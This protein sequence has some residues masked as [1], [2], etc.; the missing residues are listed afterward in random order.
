M[1]K[2]T[3]IILMSIIFLGL[4]LVGYL[5]SGFSVPNII[6]AITA[7]I[8]FWYTWETNEIRKINQEQWQIS[9]EQLKKSKQP[10]VGYKL[11]TNP[12][13]PILSNFVIINQSEYG[14]AARIKCNFKIDGNVIDDV[15]P[16]YDAKEYWNLQYKQEKQGIFSIFDLLIKAKIFT[17]AEKARIHVVTYSEND[18]REI[19]AQINRL[20][21]NKFEL[22]SELEVYCENAEGD[23]IFYPTVHYN[24]DINRMRWI[25]KI[26]DDKP[27]W[28]FGSKP[29]WV[30]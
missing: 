8:I 10:V 12:E 17:N 23:T 9:Q 30:E 16:E 14:V 18:N 21:E 3:A 15:W 5:F 28:E 13:N 7:I 20:K 6:L 27:L 22:T 4:I 26:T 1:K 19:Q 25:P 24:F 2:S 11:F 29:N